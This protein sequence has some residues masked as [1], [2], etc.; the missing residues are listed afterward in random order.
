MWLQN[1][2]LR[3]DGGLILRLCVSSGVCGV[4]VALCVNSDVCVCVD[5][6][7]KVINFVF[8]TQNVVNLTSEEDDVV[9][10][11]EK[12]LYSV[13]IIN[14][15]NR[16]GFE[17]R[18]WDINCE[19]D[20]LDDMRTQINLEFDEF[21]DNGMFQ[22]GYIEPGHGAKGRQVLITNSEHISDMYQTYEGRKQIVLWLKSKPSK[23]ST[24]KYEVRRRKRPS[25][26]NLLE[27]PDKAP[28]VSERDDSRDTVT[29]AKPSR[30]KYES[31]YLS[32]LTE[33]EK[34]LD[35]LQEKHE[36]SGKYSIEQLRAWA[37]M[38]NMKKHESYDD[39]PDKPF[40]RQSKSKKQP[41]TITSALSPGKRIQYRSECINQLDKW[42][43]LM[44]RGAI[45]S[46][47]YKDLQDSI[48]CDIQ[49][50]Q[51]NQ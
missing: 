50:F 25:S 20:D 11:G 24:E 19:F 34:N 47:Q 48:L 51:A 46:E 32:K 4:C 39:P 9:S 10:V 30:S 7:L 36:A 1:A 31:S 33:V 41:S 3:P 2:V 17:I 13:K 14:P 37:H 44:E 23:S 12:R 45:T 40:F 18:K 15:N 8:H 38:L 5:K 6:I 27:P 29:K 26:E 43:S 42:H 49:K 28:R 35:K 16:S 21:I 22:F